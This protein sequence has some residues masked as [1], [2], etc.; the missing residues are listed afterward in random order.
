MTAITHDLPAQRGAAVGA[1]QSRS[2]YLVAAVCV[3]IIAMMLFPL[4]VSFFASIKTPEEAVAVPPDYLPH[5]L[6]LANYLKVFSYQAGLATYVFNSLTV[7]FLT[8]LFCLALAVPAGYGLARFRLPGREVIFLFLLASL[9]V[10]YQALLTPLYLMFAP[11]GLTNSYIGLAIVHTVLQLPFSIYLMRHS[12]EAV[13][14]E[15]EEAAVMDGCTSLQALKRVFLPAVRPGM[16]TVILFAFI[17]SWNEFIAAL[18][19]MGKETMFTVP[20]MLVSVRLG[21]FGTVDWGALQAGII[22]AIVPCVAIYVLLQRYYV[23][24]FLSGAVK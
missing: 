12:F 14:R 4:V 22:I 15:L 23:A 13:P 7:A 5:Q 3:A 9:M 10:P 19:F 1:A 6:S 17:Q 18:I 16:V 2:V 20:I 21:R 8:I 11:L 24:G